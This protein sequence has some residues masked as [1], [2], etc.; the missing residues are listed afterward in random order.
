LCHSYNTRHA[1][2]TIGGLHPFGVKERR[3]GL[4]SLRAERLG[5]M[6]QVF[7]MFFVF[8]PEPRSSST[9]T[10]TTLSRVEFQLCHCAPQG[11]SFLATLG[12]EAE[13]PWD[14]RVEAAE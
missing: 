12:F 8:G 14:S 11:S 1:T 4:I 6:M 3:L 10:A 13:S 9:A 7:P 5:V 2:I